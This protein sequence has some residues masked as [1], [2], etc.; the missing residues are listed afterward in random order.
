MREELFALSPH[1][2]GRLSEAGFDPRRFRGREDL[3]RLPFTTRAELAADPES[4]VLL[5]TPGGVRKHWGFGRKLALVAGGKRAHTLLVHSYRPNFELLARDGIA[6]RCTPVDL[7]VLGELGA[8]VLE[9]L[10]LS[11]ALVLN[12]LPCG[13]RTDWWLPA[14]AGVAGQQVVAAEEELRRDAPACLERLAAG[15]LAG[16]FASDDLVRGVREL[17]RRRGVEIGQ[18]RTV[19][20][21]DRD[22]PALEGAAGL[23]VVPEARVA[24]PRDVHDETTSYVTWPDL[25]LLEVVDPESLE[26]VREGEPGELVYTSLAGHGTVLF[27]YRTGWIAG[28]GLTWE[29]CRASGR[30][31]PRIA[32]ELTRHED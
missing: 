29:P 10:G 9:V 8:R 26:P 31:L 13:R 30:T 22:P 24:F 14:L 19:V 4:F 32:G 7:D 20:P 15:D 11:D 12:A 1:Y 17:A 5:P 27:R 25:G 16:W 18:L 6:I 3:R 28:G 2:R 23:L 21:F